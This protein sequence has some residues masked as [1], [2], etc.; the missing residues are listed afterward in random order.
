MIY[1]YESLINNYIYTCCAAKS[2]GFVVSPPPHLSLPPTTSSLV[3]LTA[4]GVSYASASAGI[5]DSTVSV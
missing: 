1:I 5:L 3:A 4:G 2:M